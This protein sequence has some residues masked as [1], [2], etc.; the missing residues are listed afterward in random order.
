MEKVFQLCVERR[1]EQLVLVLPHKM[2]AQAGLLE[3]DAVEIALR[4]KAPEALQLELEAPS[5]AHM[6]SQFDPERHGGECM[7]GRPVGREFP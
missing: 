2:L 5:L 3:G 6:L 1:G 7:A 4:G